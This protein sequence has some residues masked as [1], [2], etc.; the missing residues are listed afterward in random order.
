MTENIPQPSLAILICTMSR[1]QE[2]NR[3]LESIAKS[4][5]QPAEI[6]VSDDSP[7]GKETEA[8]CSGFP[9]V[10]YFGSKPHLGGILDNN[11]GKKTHA[12][13]PSFLTSLGIP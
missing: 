6:V 7:D 1:P 13:H 2:L 10:R 4:G 5:R 9:L 11:L 8:V 3:C 12:F